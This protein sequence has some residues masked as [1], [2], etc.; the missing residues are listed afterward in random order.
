MIIDASV[1]LRA[2]FPDEEQVEAQELI[3]DHVAGRV[4]LVA[5]TLILYELI[6]SVRQAERR[7]RITTQEGE[8]ILESF[9]RLG[10]KLEAVE[11]KET[12]VLARE[13]DR[14]GY[15]AAYLALAKAR[16]EKL[17]TGDQRLY[18]AVRDHLDWVEYIG[19]NGQT[20]QD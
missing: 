20:A 5:P 17:I 7:E 4:D 18:N 2:Y 12:L 1:V 19:E 6:N 3:R 13:F 16:G 9:E 8:S 10:I 11:W 14:S 15:D